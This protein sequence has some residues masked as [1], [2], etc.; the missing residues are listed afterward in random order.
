MKYLFCYITLSLLNTI[1]FAQPF[2][3]NTINQVFSS[4]IDYKYQQFKLLNC[5][6][7]TFEK[8]AIFFGIESKSK[9]IFSNSIFKSKCSFKKCKFPRGANFDFAEFYKKVDMGYLKSEEKMSFYET[10]FHQNF[11][12]WMG[13]FDASVTFTSNKFNGDAIFIGSIFQDLTLNDAKFSGETRFDECVFA[14]SLTIKNTSIAKDIN[15]QN[16]QL[17]NHVVFDGIESEGFFQ[18]NGV[19]L[20]DTLELKNLDLTLPLDF[21]N[22]NFSKN[23]HCL[24]NLENVNISDLWLDFRFFTLWFSPYSQLDNTARNKLFNSLI[25][26]E[27]KRKRHKSADALEKQMNLFRNVN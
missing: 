3:L 8:E 21:D 12:L 6:S 7:S 5:D 19:V 4:P 2:A 18:F 17:G 16:A 11:F 9:A 15:F 20:P 1:C 26:Q 25:Q 13:T 27:K 22:A 24:V 23:N 14:N 10:Y